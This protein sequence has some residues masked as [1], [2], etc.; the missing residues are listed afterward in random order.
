MAYRRG[1]GGI[2]HC[3]KLQRSGYGLR[4][5]LRG[6]RL[7]PAAATPPG[8]TED[9]VQEEGRSWAAG[10]TAA[11]GPTGPAR[12]SFSVAEFS[13]R[14]QAAQRAAQQREMRTTAPT[15]RLE[16]SLIYE[17]SL[18]SNYRLPLMVMAPP[19]PAKK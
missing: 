15:S 16:V 14:Q 10:P 6:K 18:C 13:H 9:Q 5:G 12:G 19:A 11:S 4:H 7:A 8:P 2:E 17:I 1:S 3:F